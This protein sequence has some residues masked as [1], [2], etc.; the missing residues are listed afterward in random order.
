MIRTHLYATLD[1]A[2]KETFFLETIP[3][4]TLE[5]NISEQRL[6]FGDLSTNC[7]LILAPVVQLP[8]REV[9]A[10][11]QTKLTN[12]KSIASISIAGPGFLNITLTPECYTQ[13]AHQSYTAIAQLVKPSTKVESCNV[14]YVSANP[15]GPLHF[16]HGRGGIIGNTLARVLQFAGVTTT[17]EF[18]INDAGRQI[19]KLGESLRIRY[20]QW[21]GQVVELPEDGYHGEY[22]QDIAK[23]LY[24]QHGTSLEGKSDEYFAQYA[25]TLLLERITQTL[26]GYGVSFDVWFSEKTLHES[27]AI[28]EAI[29]TLRERGHVYEHDDALWFRSTSFGDDKDRVL[30]RSNGSWTYVAADIAYLLNKLNRGFKKLV[31]VLGQDHHSYVVRLHAVLQA[32]GYDKSV[33]DIIL[34]QLVTIKNEGELVR[35]SKRSGNIVALD[36]VVEAVGK[37][38]ARFFYLNRKPDAHLDFDIGLAL[39]QTDENPVYYIQYALVRC[40]SIIRNA[41]ENSAFNNINPADMTE[42]TEYERLLLRKIASLKNTLETVINSYQTHLISYYTIE[43]AQLLHRYYSTHRVIDAENIAI[44]RHRLAVISC[45]ENALELCLELLGLSLPE[46]M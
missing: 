43:L 3:S 17:A 9:A 21:C 1:K 5:W 8:P 44:S 27:G 24:D 18:Y 29:D 46:S 7:A 32:F 30:K 15:T 37:D 23:E 22:L 20:A 33:L 41:L 36:D 42:F 26:E 11:I 34:Y 19:L 2:L 25:Q 39:K 13:L 28:D 40:K 12:D 35:L 38:C 6:N 45:M 10:I 4:Y 16:G 31:M 14:E